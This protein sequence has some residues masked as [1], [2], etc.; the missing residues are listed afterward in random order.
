MIVWL[1]SYPR[2]GNTLYRTL[3]YH[4]TGQR[5]YSVHNDP[6]FSR[7]GFGDEVGHEMLPVGKG[8]FFAYGKHGEQFPHW[9]KV[10]ALIDSE[11]VYLT[12]THAQVQGLP[13]PSKAI[14]IV[15]DGRDAE[16]SFVHYQLR[17]HWGKS[18]PQEFLPR[19]RVR[20]KKDCIWGDHVMGWKEKAVAIVRFED[21][22]E[23]PRKAVRESLRKAGVPF[24]MKS[25]VRVPAFAELHAKAPEFFRR[26]QVGCYKDEMPVPLQRLYWKRYGEALEAMGYD[27]S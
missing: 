8:A 11:K 20:V 15:R 19:L 12:K 5:T 4:Y 10:K 13:F 6:D 21:M 3:V 27:H 24:T 25:D 1:V 2:S 17:K 23:H 14:Y 7:K 26:G 9:Q 22:L 16:V 18:K